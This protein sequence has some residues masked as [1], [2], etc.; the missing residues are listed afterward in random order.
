M[1]PSARRS[2][3]ALMLLALLTQAPQNAYRMQKFL[4]MSDKAKVV[5]IGSRNSIY[6]SLERLERDGL[7]AVHERAGRDSTVYEL[8]DT[9]WDA[10]QSWLADTLSTP[11]EEFPAFPAALSAAALLTPEQLADLLDRRRGH[12]E[13][14]LAA[15][16]PSEVAK[17]EGIARIFLIEEE[18]RRTVLAAELDWLTEII[19]Q[20]RD[21]TFAWP[22]LT[23]QPPGEAGP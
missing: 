13:A 19:A 4:I 20:L 9:G 10:L 5:N 12:L 6:Q 15:P 8:T 11:R 22:G 3:L 7:I 16:G 17:E 2:P 18:Y 1:P 21:R 23:R 14:M